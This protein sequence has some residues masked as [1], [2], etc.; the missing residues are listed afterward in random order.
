MK[1][2]TLAASRFPEDVSLW[3]KLGDARYAAGKDMPALAAYQNA[4]KADRENGDAQR[5]LVRVE[6]VLRIDPTRRGL[7]VRERARRWDEVLQRVLAATAVCRPS[8][9]TAQAKQFLNK[10]AV[11]LEAS[12]QKMEA[13]KSIWR[14]AESSC[15]TDAVLAHVMSKIEEYQ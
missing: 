3:L 14:D 9:E 2:W 6:D 12:D 13:A 8:P 10:P 7:T 1:F 5:A 15:K 11:S 4:A